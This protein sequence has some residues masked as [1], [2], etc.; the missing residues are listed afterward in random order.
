MRYKELKMSITQKVRSKEI[1]TISLENRD[2]RSYKKLPGKNIT[3]DMQSVVIDPIDPKRISKEFKNVTMSS[4]VKAGAVFL[5]TIGL[6]YFTKTTGIFSSFDWG[7]ENSKDTGNRNAMEIKNKESALNIKT[8]LETKNQVNDPSLNQIS[9][10]YRNKD[11]NVKFEEIKVEKFKDLPEVEKKNVGMRR[12]SSRRSI[13]IQNPISDQNAIVGKFFELT[14]DGTFV[15]TSNIIFLKATNIPAWLTS[16]TPNPTFIGSYNTPGWAMGV[17]VSRNYAYVADYE[18]G[19]LVIDISD[20]S[21]PTFKGSYDTIYDNYICARDVAL[22]GN[23]AYV[24]DQKSLLIIVANSR[25]PTFKGSCGTSSW[26][27]GV[28]L[29]GDYAYVAAANSGLQIIDIS[30]PANPTFKGSC[31]NMHGEANEVAL[32]GNYAYV[33]YGSYEYSSGLQIIDISDPSNPTLKGLYDTPDRA[34]GVAVS[35]NYAYV[36]DGY[37]GGLQIIDISDPSNPTFKGSYD[38]PSFAYG[39]AVSGSYA[40][41]SDQNS[42][43][44]IID[45]SDP[46]NPTFKGGYGMPNWARD[47]ALSGN[48]VYVVDLLSLQIIATNLDKLTLTGIASSVGTYG[49]DIEACNDAMECV[50]DSFNI[51]ARNNRAPIVANPIQNQTAIINAL[52]NYIFPTNIFI[53]PDEHSLTYTAKSSNNEPLPSWLNF[54]SPQRKFSGTPD[55]LA[56]YPIKVIANDGYD[57]SVST[58][59]NLIV[60]EDLTTTLLN[61]TTLLISL[62][63][64][65]ICTTSFCCALIAG[66]G[67]VMLRQHRNKILG[68][69][70]NTDEKEVKEEKE[71]QKLKTNYD[72]K[73]VVDNG[74]SQPLEEQKTFTEVRRDEGLVYYPN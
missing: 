48:Y 2:V 18:S 6:Y 67:I 55:E 25:N 24:A 3:F 7:E 26:A 49:V 38:T 12:S 45:I 31:N 61:T 14:I 8:N 74:V 13:S 66:G 51:I 30:D 35:G 23:Y 4:V 56:T 16:R 32:S 59:F 50:T 70:S 21:N 47:V 52:F 20:P 10:T 72:K 22:S 57:G 28:A 62:I 17:A 60:K 46:S 54:Y 27:Y 73:I 15:F 68:N 71:L 19:L 29:S 42:G 41:V 64:G 1:D 43:L 44:Q 65:A 36:A 39:V 9:K 5:I 33:A 34:Y 11:S 40:Y 37:A 69:E 63:I 53:D 58:V